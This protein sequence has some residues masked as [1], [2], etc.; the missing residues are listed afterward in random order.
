MTLTPVLRLA[1]ERVVQIR[2]PAANEQPKAGEQIGGDDEGSPA[3][4]LADVDVFVGVGAV[5]RWRVEAEDD[6]A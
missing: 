3:F 4:A 6:V 1:L 2:P 5:E